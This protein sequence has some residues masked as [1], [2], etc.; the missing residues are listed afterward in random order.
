M[1]KSLI[2]KCLMGQSFLRHTTRLLALSL[3]V[4]LGCR[5]DPGTLFDT[6][7]TAS[8]LSPPASPT[9]TQA[10]D[11]YD[12][13]NYTQAQEA[14]ES[15]LKADPQSPDAQKAQYYLARTLH[16]LA[17]IEDDASTPAAS[18]PHFDAALSAYQKLI[19]TYPPPNY[20]NQARYYR[21]RIY[22]DRNDATPQ[23]YTLAI[24][25]WALVNECPAATKCASAS[26]Y[27]ARAHHKNKDL[28]SAKAA[29][30]HFITTH[31]D[32]SDLHHAHYYR[33]LCAYEIAGGIDESDPDL[34]QAQSATI[35]DNYD[36]AIADFESV[37][38]ATNSSHA[39]EANYYLGKCHYQKG[40]Y[41]TALATFEDVRS[42]YPTSSE[43]VW[44]HYYQAKC[45]YKDVANDL[46]NHTAAITILDAILN[47]ATYDQETAVLGLSHY[48]KG[49]S[50]VALGNDTSAEE[51]FDALISNY[52]TIAHFMVPA[53]HYQKGK[54]DYFN[55]LP[56]QATAH[57]NT[58]LSDWSQSFI[59]PG[60][61]YY[62]LKI[63]SDAAD[64]TQAQQQ[65]T[66]LSTN[67]PTS[68]YAT[69][70]Q[71]YY[72]SKCN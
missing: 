39:S 29:Y 33:G 25:E 22:Y 46:S 36:E 9:Y 53:A 6:R 65:L 24:N 67:H 15:I 50:Y 31:P 47:E 11:L 56:T 42:T 72:D 3:L 35:T 5:P 37:L 59:V 20:H 52:T 1:Q 12:T 68:L 27:T 62:K 69:Y 19:D 64:C 43:A 14:F 38:A 71:N 26:Y 40:D 10:R 49:K 4:G 28:E 44:A 18:N 61:V 34:Q 58:V 41:T 54:I 60:C 66:T 63:S 7:P 70:G 21:G 23:R 48:L 30:L 2:A 57:F 55:T 17:D 51:A 13:Q 45:H 16:R 8:S 32:S